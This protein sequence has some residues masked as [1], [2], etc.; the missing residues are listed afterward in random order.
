MATL[1]RSS[2]GERADA[3]VDRA[4]EAPILPFAGAAPEAAPSEPAPDEPRL[5]EPGRALAL[6][7]V[8][9][10]TSGPGEALIRLAYRL[11]V[12]GHAIAAPFRRPQALRLLATVESPHR[13]DR[14]AGTALRAGHFL[15]HASACR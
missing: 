8:I 10:S 7:D 2:A 14:T 5:A 3:L 9:A 13:G 11:G 12:P 4:A 15:I 6:S 1:L